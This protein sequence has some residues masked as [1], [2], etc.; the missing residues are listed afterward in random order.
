MGTISSIF[1]LMPLFGIEMPSFDLSGQLEN[2]TS[3]LESLKEEELE[4][5]YLFRVNLPS[6]GTINLKSNKD[7]LLTNIYY[8][9]IN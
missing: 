7:F 9:L 3:I 6:I 4:D 5:G 2:A 8:I 1:D